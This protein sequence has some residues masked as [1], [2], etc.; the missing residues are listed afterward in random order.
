MKTDVENYKEVL[1]ARK[2]LLYRRHLKMSRVRMKLVLVSSIVL[3]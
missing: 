2:D 3:K 1:I